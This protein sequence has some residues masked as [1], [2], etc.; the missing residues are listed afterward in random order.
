MSEGGGCKAKTSA[1]KLLKE[2]GSTFSKQNLVELNLDYL[3]LL[4]SP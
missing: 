3:S 2:T 1:S 4:P